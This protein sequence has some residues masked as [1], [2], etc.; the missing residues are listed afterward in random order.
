MSEVIDAVVSTE[1]KPEAAAVVPRGNILDV[2]PKKFGLALD[3]R[4]ANRDTLMTWIRGAL[5]EGTDFGCIPTKKGPSKPSLWKPGAEKICGMLGV[6]VNFPTLKDYERATVEGRKIE[7][8]ILRCELVDGNGYVVAEGMGARSYTQDG[9]LNKM[10]KMAAKSAHI[11]AT[12]RMAGISEVFTQ[13]I[14]DIAAAGTFGGQASGTA[15]TTN[16]PQN[17]PQGQQKAFENLICPACGVRSLGRSKYPPKGKPNAEPGHYCYPASGGC[18]ASYTLDAKAVA[19]INHTTGTYG[20]LLEA[21][22]ECTHAEELEEQ[23]GPAVK[24][25]WNEL[26]MAQKGEVRAKVEQARMT[27]PKGGKP[28]ETKPEDS[29]PF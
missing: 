15:S 6:I 21:I 17:A 20:K 10:L 13:D 8:V 18:G 25:G 22:A 28:V 19:E 2:D 26:T 5:V 7:H 3:N 4:K 29:I 14:E 27:L 9:E 23:V 16:G 11:D 24:A 12:L 1:P